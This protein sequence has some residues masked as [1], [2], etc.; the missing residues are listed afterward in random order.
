MIILAAWC[1]VAGHPGF[2]FKD[3][4]VLGRKS[5]DGQSESGPEEPK[6]VQEAMA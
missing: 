3:N 2:V 1:L 6:V 4:A 5:S